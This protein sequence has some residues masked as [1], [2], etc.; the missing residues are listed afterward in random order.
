MSLPTLLDIDVFVLRLV[1]GRLEPNDDAI[2]ARFPKALRRQFINQFQLWAGRT[3]KADTLRRATR[4]TANTDGVI[5]LPQDFLCDAIVWRVSGQMILR[6]PFKVLDTLS[7]TNRAEFGGNSDST[8]AVPFSDPITGAPKIQ[9]APVPSDVATPDAF[10]VSYIARPP[11]LVHETETMKWMRL[12]EDLALEFPAYYAAF[13]I[14]SIE[15]VGTLETTATF[16]A[17]L[18]EMKQEFNSY[19]ETLVASDLR[20]H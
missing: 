15:G 3:L 20:I 11:I 12:Y 5:S 10:F 6:K 19:N 4:L 2:N 7:L 13:R 1:Q 8:Y 9:L 14:M 16:S 17:R 18:A